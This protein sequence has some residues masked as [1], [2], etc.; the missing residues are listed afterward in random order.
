[1]GKKGLI[2]MGPITF[3][4]W[5]SIYIKISKVGQGKKPRV[6]E[7]ISGKWK[8]CQ[9]R[10]DSLNAGLEGGRWGGDGVRGKNIG[11]KG[12][13][14]RVSSWPW[15]DCIGVSACGSFPAPS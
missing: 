1:M 4:F 9:R 5:F 13:V 10:G 11:V 12:D 7:R 6:W 14:R 8:R 2:R 3:M 15:S